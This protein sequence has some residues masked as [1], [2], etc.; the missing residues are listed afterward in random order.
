MGKGAAAVKLS[1]T[2][3]V[4]LETARTLSPRNRQATTATPHPSLSQ[5]PR[6]N[7]YSK[8]PSI[9]TATTTTT[10]R[11]AIAMA[12]TKPTDKT[13]QPPPPQRA[14][15]SRL[16]FLYQAGALLSLPVGTPAEQPS[17]PVGL[18]RYYTSHLLSV[19]RKSV[20]RLSP[21][22]KHSICKRCCS[23]LIP[24]VS[25]T[26]R[27]ENTSK[28]ERK[29]WADVL[30]VQCTFCKACKRFPMLDRA[31]FKS[32]ASETKA[33]KDKDISDA[34]EKGMMSKERTGGDTMAMDICPADDDTAP[35]G[36]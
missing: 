20:Q 7:R 9:T 34:P 2:S 26:N 31:Q 14:V 35:A 17:A 32:K 29:P 19:S 24:G 5:P 4:L 10:T 13:P 18:S 16:S 21:A 12:K 36:T 27:V 33:A 3:A 8:I 25:C 6:H 11:R 23:V 15:L 1:P 30:V 28:N 22:V